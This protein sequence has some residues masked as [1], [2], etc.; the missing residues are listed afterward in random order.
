MRVQEKPLKPNSSFAVVIALAHFALLQGSA[1]WAAQGAP[2]PKLTLGVDC[3]PVNTF[4]LRRMSPVHRRHR[5][6]RRRCFMVVVLHR[7][8]FNSQILADLRWFR[9]PR[10]DTRHDNRYADH[11]HLDEQERHH[12]P[13]NLWRLHRWRR[14][15]PEVVQCDAERRMHERRLQVDGDQH[16]KPGSAVSM[17]K[18]WQRDPVPLADEKQRE[19][20][21][22]ALPRCGGGSK[23][24]ALGRLRGNLGV[25]STTKIPVVV[26][27]KRADRPTPWAQAE[28]IACVKIEQ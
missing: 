23:C 27:R 3:L 19:A 12:A 28:E 10:Y 24:P 14:H 5:R 6:R 22:G 21:T 20:H 18:Q 11:Q 16:G 9:G 7:R 15:A 13:I 17:N 26:E 25:E 1:A 2:D 4:T 8:H